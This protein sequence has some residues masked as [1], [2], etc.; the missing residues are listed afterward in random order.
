MKLEEL[1]NK[2]DLNKIE[3]KP[4]I[5]MGEDFGRDYLIDDKGNYLM[6][7]SPLEFKLIEEIKL[8]KERV[9]KLEG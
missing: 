5:I 4:N 8:L 9:E 2:I 1:K 6:P 3:V 7:V